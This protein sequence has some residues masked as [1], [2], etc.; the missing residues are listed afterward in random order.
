M[1]RNGQLL[2]WCVAQALGQSEKEPA[3]T[4]GLRQVKSPQSVLLHDYEP[5]GRLVSS[6]QQGKPPSDSM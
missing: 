2:T 4:D 5:A 1:G 3:I 6:Y